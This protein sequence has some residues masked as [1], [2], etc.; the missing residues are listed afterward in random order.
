MQARL[1][2]DSSRSRPMWTS[3]CRS[4]RLGVH[5]QMPKT[6]LA[7]CADG[8]CDTQPTHRSM[9]LVRGRHPPGPNAR[10]ETPP[11]CR[12]EARPRTPAERKATPPARLCRRPSIATYH[13]RKLQ[14]FSRRSKYDTSP[15]FARLEAWIEQCAPPAARLRQRDDQPRPDAQTSSASRWRSRPDRPANVP[16]QSG[17]RARS[18][19]DFAMAIQSRCRCLAL[20]VLRPLL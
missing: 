10:A 16:I 4:A 18:A 15:T 1:S 5:E 2:L 6:L 12:M 9:G 13:P 11:A 8:V 20:A 3:R 17:H 14:A 19:L 7:S